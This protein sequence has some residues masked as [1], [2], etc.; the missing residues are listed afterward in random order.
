L[1]NLLFRETEI[2]NLEKAV[3]RTLF[4][5]DR[6][7]I[8]GISGKA[9]V[10]KSIL[11]NHVLSQVEQNDGSILRLS[12]N[13]SSTAHR[14]DF[15]ALIDKL[16]LARVERSQNSN[17]A[18]P[19]TRKV[20]RKHAAFATAVSDEMDRKN[21]DQTLKE[22]MLAMIR[23]GRY[24]NKLV[25]HTKKFVN[26]EALEKSSDSKRTPEKELTSLASFATREVRFL[27]S[28]IQNALGI[29]FRN[30]LRRDPYGL[31]ARALL[32]D[33][34][35][36]VFD[37]E[38]CDPEHKSGSEKRFRRV[39]IVID[40]FETLGACLSDFLFSSLLPLAKDEDFGTVLI[41]V[42]RDDL[43]QTL[44]PSIYNQYQRSIKAEVSLEPF[45]RDQTISFLADNG[46]V[47]PQSED[48]FDWSRGN[49][50]LLSLRRRS[51]HNLNASREYYLRG[52]QWMSVEQIEWF[53][54]LVY[55]EAVNIDTLEWLFDKEQAPTIQGWFEDQYDIRDVN[56]DEFRVE[57]V[58]RN[59][60]LYYLSKHSPVQHE[61][62]L[63][64]IS[65]QLNGASQPNL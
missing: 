40:D 37:P 35:R 19:G 34:R 62:I 2:D 45:N 10:G 44:S 43:S 63:N 56:A 14:D 5:A 13:G 17:E 60:S 29:T 31:A 15:F 30:D 22:T 38:L 3:T 26:F 65:E 33:L 4:L 8:I 21:L 27:P 24:A 61:N 51:K 18:F 9:G 32:D 12:V 55:L 1:E 54:K 23:A 39:V 57:P 42:G 25:P 36:L 16:T 58:L 47:G 20:V 11:T 41:V 52:T 48:I 64:I 7:T 6:L 59:Q 49:P 28:P 46:I 53:N 50:Y